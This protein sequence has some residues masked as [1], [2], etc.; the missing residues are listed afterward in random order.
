MS[1]TVTMNKYLDL[2][3]LCIKFGADSDGKITKTKLAKLAFLADFAFFYEQL[4]PISGFTYKKLEQG[5]VPM[6]FFWALSHLA[7][8]GVITIERKKS[9]R[10]D[11]PIELISL[12]SNKTKE[13]NELS[14]QEIGTIK[15]VSKK[16]KPYNTESIVKFTHDQLPWKI[17]KKNDEI[18]YELITQE[19][20]DNVF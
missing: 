6:E 10:S 8:Q 1:A 3:Q 17:S 4:K 19:E 18:P 5:P 9:S 16:W 13:F 20:Q 7:D 14:T 15:K 12:S 2:I 11:K